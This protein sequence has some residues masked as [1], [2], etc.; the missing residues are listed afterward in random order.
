MLKAVY[1]TVNKNENK[2]LINVITNRLS[3]LKDEIK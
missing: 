1:N 3:D 2:D